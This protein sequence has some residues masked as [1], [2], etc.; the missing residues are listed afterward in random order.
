MIINLSQKFYWTIPFIVIAVVLLGLISG[1]AFCYHKET[2]KRV[3]CL[4]TADIPREA[5]QLTQALESIPFEVVQ[6]DGIKEY[7]NYD[8][9]TGVK[10]TKTSFNPQGQLV[11]I[12]AYEPVSGHLISE[13]Y[14][15]ADTNQVESILEYDPI[16]TKLLQKTSYYHL[17]NQDPKDNCVYSK[18]IEIYDKNVGRILQ[19]TYYESPKEEDLISRKKV[20]FK[21]NSYL[22]IRYSRFLGISQFPRI[23]YIDKYDSHGECYLRDIYFYYDSELNKNIKLKFIE[24]QIIKSDQ[25]YCVLKFIY[26]NKEGVLDKIIDICD[27][28]IKKGAF[29]EKIF[30]I[31]NSPFKIN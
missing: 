5:K 20:F 31:D 23:D 11:S 6:A 1:A 13:T 25:K 14:Y 19:T 12:A 4:K 16:T 24:E 29:N 2:E 15:Q 30:Y 3:P 17:V 18:Y 27:I 9:T 22:D 26:F 21:D 7:Y 28:D 10:K 8:P